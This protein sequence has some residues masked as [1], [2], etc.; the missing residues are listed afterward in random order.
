M[1]RKTMKLCIA[2]L[3]LFTVWS[4]AQEGTTFYGGWPYELP[5]DGH[6]NTFASKAINLGTYQP[7]MEPPLATYIWDAGTYEGMAASEFGFDEDNN[8]VVTLKPDI[9]WSDGT[10]LTSEDVVAT[11]NTAYLIG[12]A[13]WDSLEKV[14]TVDDMTVKFTLS[15]PSFAAERL[16]L[17][18]YLRPAS[19]Y[20]TFA[21]RAAPLIERKA[22]AGDPEFDALL[23]EL[24]EFR[25]EMFIAAGPYVLEAENI[26]DSK[27]TLV[28]NPGGVGGDTAAFDNVVLWNGET[29]AVTPL[30]ASGQLWYGTYGFPPATEKSFVDA[31]IDII[32]GPSYSG[33]ALYFNHSV[34]PFD[35]PEVRRAL[36]HVIDREENGFVSLGESGVAVE[37]M[38]GFSDNLAE[39][40]LSDETLEALDPYDYDVE[41]ATAMLEEIGFTKGSDGVWLDD[42]GNRMAF[43]LIFP[44]EFAD[45]AA[46]AENAT[47]ALNDF[48]F[49]ITARGVQFQQ[50]QQ[51]VYDSN[52]ELAIRNWGIGSPL[53][54]LSYLEPYRRYN[55]QG[56]LAGQQAQGM[57]FDTNVTY[58]G[59]ELDVV[60]AAIDSSKGLDTDAQNA[61][62][63][64]LALSFN[65]LLPII[66]LWE[67]YGNNPLNREFLNAPPGD[68]PIYKNSGADHFMPYMIVTGK[69]TPV[70]SQ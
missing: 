55:G 12:A 25:P 15:E 23:Q 64:Q 39:L 50:Q 16:I 60:Q 59:G 56:E 13:A 2:L 41:A 4:N 57:K 70:E 66:P 6:F 14:E 30:V 28:K 69:I 21:E 9:T 48:G 1:M 22:E 18:T 37:Y 65:E 42:Q 63:E 34:A 27:V 67:R 68:D 24:T 51:D 58:S 10:P 8:Y 61:I 62:I 20:G 7:L 54:Y 32:R 19:V 26:S 3:A 5:P 40:Y 33:P 36:A 47:Q 52:F 43:E 35:R 29:E 49:E 11:F 44:A 31:G 38:M 46:A 17:I 45:W 53:P